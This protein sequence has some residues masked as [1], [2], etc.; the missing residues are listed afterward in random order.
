MW[1]GEPLEDA[2]GRMSVDEARHMLGSFQEFPSYYGETMDVPL[3]VNL[4]KERLAALGWRIIHEYMEAGT[5][6]NAAVIRES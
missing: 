5:C 6:L 1:D 3:A 2:L 4:V